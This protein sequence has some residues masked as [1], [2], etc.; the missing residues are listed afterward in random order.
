MSEAEMEALDAA[1]AERPEGI[2]ESE[3]SEVESE[4][5]SETSSEAE[6]EDKE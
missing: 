6:A 2:E 4:S 1:D 3:E 5:D